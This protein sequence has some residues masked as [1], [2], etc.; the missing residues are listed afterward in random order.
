MLDINHYNALF[1]ATPGQNDATKY[2][3][4][5]TQP[6]GPAHYRCIGIHHLTP[7]ENSGNHHAYLDVLDQQGQRIREA[8][9]EWT[10][11]GRRLEEPAPPPTLD[12]PDTEPGTN[13]P[14]QWAQTISV[15]VLGHP[16]DTVHNLH[17]RHPDEGDGGNTRGHHSFYVVFQR[18]DAAGGPP[19]DSVPPPTPPPGAPTTE[20]L[21]VRIA[22]LHL[23]INVAGDKLQDVIDMLREA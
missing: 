15:A 20:Q 6:A 13:I 21:L 5:T 11:I 14:I 10:W 3:V 22:E 12:K 1:L 19:I 18:T 16:S 17:T 4:D 23:V 9:I 7:E 8:Q 2:G